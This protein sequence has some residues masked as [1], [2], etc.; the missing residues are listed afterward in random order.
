MLLLQVKASTAM[1]AAATVGAGHKPDATCKDLMFDNA[2]TCSHADKAPPAATARA[3]RAGHTNAA[4]FTEGD[5]LFSISQ[6]CC[7]GW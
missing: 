3:D 7:P 2:S 4:G 1:Q 6:S 5:C